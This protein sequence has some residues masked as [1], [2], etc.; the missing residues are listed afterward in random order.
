MLPV[1]I[2]MF[3]VAIVIS[4]ARVTDRVDPGATGFAAGF[5]ILGVVS[6]LSY[7]TSRDS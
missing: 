6:M 7:W 3:V 5:F 2:L 4:A 1:S